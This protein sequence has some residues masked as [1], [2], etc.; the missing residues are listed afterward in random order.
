[1]DQPSL[2]P[3]CNF[4]LCDITQ[5]FILEFC[6]LPRLFL[7]QDQ[8]AEA[9][10]VCMVLLPESGKPHLPQPVEWATV[11][12]QPK[13]ALTSRNPHTVDRP[14][15]GH[16]EHLAK[17]PGP[18]CQTGTPAETESS[19][20]PFQI[21]LASEEFR[22]GRGCQGLN[23]TPLHPSSVC[24]CVCFV[25]NNSHFLESYKVLFQCN[26]RPQPTSFPTRVTPA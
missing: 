15:I 8:E 9:V 20:P 23:A 17:S 18:P 3:P 7:I 6:Q 12:F 11:G 5:I 26:F 21:I 24:P 10:L 4:L 25:L 13:L 19:L 16:R 2:K 1:M 22:W 14:H